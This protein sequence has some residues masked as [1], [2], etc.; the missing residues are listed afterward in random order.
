[1]SLTPG[2]QTPPLCQ[3]GVANYNRLRP[4][5]VP[6]ATDAEFATTCGGG[7]T[8]APGSYGC[9]LHGTPSTAFADQLACWKPAVSG[10]HTFRVVSA[11]AG[12]ALQGAACRILSP[13]ANWTR[14]GS[15]GGSPFYQCFARA[16]GVVVTPRP[17]DNAETRFDSSIS[18]FGYTL[19]TSTAASYVDVLK[20]AVQGGL[21]V[22]VTASA[23]ATIFSSGY[24]A[25]SELEVRQAGTSRLLGL[26]I[27]DGQASVDSPWVGGVDALGHIT[28]DASTVNLTGAALV[29]D[30]ATSILL[31]PVGAPSV[32]R[33]GNQMVIEGTF[34]DAVDNINFMLHVELQD[35]Q[36]RPTAA[37]AGPSEVECTS[38]D[39]A[40]ATFTGTA[41]APGNPSPRLSWV[42]MGPDYSNGRGLDGVATATFPLPLLT[43]DPRDRFGV[44]FSVYSGDLADT[45]NTFVRV[46][47]TQPPTIGETVVDVPC[48]WGDPVL[49]AQQTLCITVTGPASDTCS[50]PTIELTEIREYYDGDPTPLNVYSQPSQNCVHADPAYPPGGFGEGI[51][52]EIDWRA[53]D[54][55]GNPSPT[56]TV[57]FKVGY[58]GLP[59]PS[60]SAE[61]SVEY[62]RR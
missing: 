50:T 59:T 30:R 24:F 7:V 55:W 57:R 60:C 15:A 26:P 47:D 34:H 11:E 45:T 52:W 43:P 36:A 5:S 18:T 20:N 19:A 61:R 1:M 41:T 14:D 25:L 2:S 44:T 48:G 32:S 49:D 39:G 17:Y 37:I 8:P 6:D 10:R 42:V 58:H 38:P 62:I 22:P 16:D 54:S 31:T 13:R 56:R 12:Y 23:S 29:N 3:V 9:N 40:S 27:I 4:T 21:R 28:I 46:V 53:R 51:E 35:T 33:H